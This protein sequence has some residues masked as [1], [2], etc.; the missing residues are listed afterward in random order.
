MKTK[1]NKKI[2]ILIF[3]ILGVVVFLGFRNPRYVD[4]KYRDDPV[5]IKTDNWESIDTSRSS[6]IRNARYDK[7]QQYMIIDLDGT[8]Y[9]YCGLPGYIWESFKDSSSLGSYYNEHIRGNYDC[10]TNSPPSY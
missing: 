6:F 8:N 2:L 1:S 4:V 3:L 9:H 5:E 10:R 7:D